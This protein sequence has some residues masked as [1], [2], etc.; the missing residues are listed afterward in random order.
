M[1]SSLDIKSNVQNRLKQLLKSVVIGLQ[2]ELE[3]QGHVA[4]KRLYNSIEEQTDFEADS[5]EG[6]ILALLYGNYMNFGVKPNRVR[7]GGS[8]HIDSLIQWSKDKGISF[9]SE[10]DRKS[11]AFA[12]IKKQKKLGNPSTRKFSKNGRVLGWATY[13]FDKMEKEILK[14]L[15]S[16][17]FDLAEAQLNRV[18]EKVAADFA[19]GD[20]LLKTEGF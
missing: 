6:K 9:E 1:T 16:I 14:G 10:K 2:K 3:G 18:L 20:S 7:F 11:F 15:E 5:L 13:T 19:N 8:S 12:T 4:S 17:G